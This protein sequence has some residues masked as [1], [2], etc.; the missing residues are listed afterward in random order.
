MYVPN[1]SFMIYFELEKCT[2]SAILT[3]TFMVNY[4]I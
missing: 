2:D 4:F 3:N 1:V